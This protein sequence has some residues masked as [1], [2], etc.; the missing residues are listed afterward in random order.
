[1]DN[2]R[3][4]MTGKRSGRL[5]RPLPLVAA[6]AVLWAAANEPT[7][8]TPAAM[9]VWLLGTL[10]VG[11]LTRAALALLEP[12]AKLGIALLLQGVPRQTPPTGDGT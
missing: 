8:F 5:I 4:R 10:T 7:D 6:A 1:M 9:V 3:H 2:D 12:L 11:L